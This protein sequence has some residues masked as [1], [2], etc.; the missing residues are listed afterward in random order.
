MRPDH[1]ARLREAASRL[2]D[3]GGSVLLVASSPDLRYLIG[4]GPMPLERPTVLVIDAA[5]DVALIVPELELPLAAAA[6]AG[7]AL[8]LRQ[9]PC[10][11]LGD[12]LRRLPQAARQFER[13]RQCQ[14]AQC[15]C[16]RVSDSER[17]LIGRGE[18]VALAQERR[19][20]RA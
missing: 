9:R 14:V 10:Q 17:R 19:E 12:D 13:H 4:Y 8:D 7:D 2:A 3:A 5:G 18:I 6:P 16:R 11:F 15:A 1:R 20:T